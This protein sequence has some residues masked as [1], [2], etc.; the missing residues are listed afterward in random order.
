MSSVLVPMDPVEP[1]MAICFTLVIFADSAARSA[2]FQVLPETLIDMGRSGA[3]Y[4][5]E[6]S[7]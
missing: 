7:T 6:V 4:E 1:R 3:S 5:G 2:L